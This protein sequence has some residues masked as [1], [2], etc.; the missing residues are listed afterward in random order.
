MWVTVLWR[1]AGCPSISPNPSGVHQCGDGERLAS[2]PC[3]P[4]EAVIV[5]LWWLH[6]GAVGFTVCEGWRSRDVTGARRE[7]DSPEIIRV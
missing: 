3:Q 1:P 5:H 7:Q 6:P 4:E 2:R